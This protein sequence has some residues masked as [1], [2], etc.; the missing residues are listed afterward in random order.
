MAKN[1]NEICKKGAKLREMLQLLTK[2]EAIAD[3]AAADYEANP[4]DAE[5][6]AEFDRAYKIEFDYMMECV[7]RLQDLINI[8]FHTAKKMIMAEREKVLEILGKLGE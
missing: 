4:E 1:T 5:I 2:F 6:E 8:D 7:A 3:H